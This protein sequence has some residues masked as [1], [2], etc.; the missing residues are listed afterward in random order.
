MAAGLS[1]A[2]A[3]MA[4]RNQKS[5]KI[6]LPSLPAGSHPPLLNPLGGGMQILGFCPRFGQIQQVAVL[7]NHLFR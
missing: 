5:R 6:L 7:R 3:R 1:K 2:S 4:V